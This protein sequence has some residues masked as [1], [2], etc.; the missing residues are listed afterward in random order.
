MQRFPAIVLC[1]ALLLVSS[2]FATSHNRFDTK[3]VLT[4]TTPRSAQAMRPNGNGQNPKSH[5][6][7]RQGAAS[8]NQKDALHQNLQRYSSKGLPR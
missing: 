4:R 1:C 3:T 7:S 6:G 5:G 8:A 2:G